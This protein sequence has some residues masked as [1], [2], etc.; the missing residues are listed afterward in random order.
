MAK[1][2]KGRDRMDRHPPELRG[3]AHNRYGGYQMQRERGL[4][5]NTYG[6][7]GPVKKYSAEE[8]RQFEVE[9]GLR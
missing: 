5:G 8:I 3:P 6:A 4:R 1:K 7:A 2:T 9:R